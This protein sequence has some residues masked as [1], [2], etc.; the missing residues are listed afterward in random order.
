MK[1]SSVFIWAKGEFMGINK[2]L[3]QISHEVYDA[4][5]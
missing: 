2:L 1:D 4:N 3:W 5:P